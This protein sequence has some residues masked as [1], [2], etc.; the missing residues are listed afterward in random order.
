MGMDCGG[1]L[2]LPF[3]HSEAGGL[4][5]MALSAVGILALSDM[6]TC[7]ASTQK[8]SSKSANEGWQLEPTERS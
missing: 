6:V 4:S 3:W 1:S 2:F 7:M 5:T 8:V